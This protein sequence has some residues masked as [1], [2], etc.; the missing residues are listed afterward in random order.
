MSIANQKIDEL[1]AD[2]AAKRDLGDLSSEEQTAFEDW[3]AAD[4]RH[5]GAY[6][7]AEAVLARLERLKG[8]TLQPAPENVSGEPGWFRRRAI[9]AGGIA[10]TLV[11]AA[12]IE[13]AFQRGA[14]E[15]TFSTEIGQMKEVVLADGSVVFLNTNS[16]ITVKFTDAERNIKLVTGEALF[17]VAK[18]KERPFIVSA[19]DTRVRAVGTSFSVSMLRRKPIQVRVKEGI[20]ELRR[21]DAPTAIPVRVSANF[22]VLAKHD[23]SIVTTPM[24]EEKL[25]RGIAWQRGRIAL[26]DRTLEDAADEF[27]RYS[28][29]R[30]MVDPAVS[31]KTVTG[32]FASNDPVGFA[33]AAASVLKLRVEVRGSE[34]RIF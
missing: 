17:D 33:K 3:L 22:Q 7:R 10:A 9:L 28:E 32:L 25:E 30:I 15:E 21:V 1:A 27:A 4:I 12:G 6:G 26:D 23:S 18:N 11:A 13:A 24:P 34:V 29:V 19:G 20:V 16:E 31:G 8:V 2:W 14:R 5:L